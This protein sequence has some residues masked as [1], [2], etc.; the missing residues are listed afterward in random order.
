MKQ[1]EEDVGHRVVLLVV[2]AAG[3]LVAV[4]VEEVELAPRRLRDSGDGL[5]ARDVLASLP[6]HHV[7]RAGVDLARERLLRLTGVASSFDEAGRIELHDADDDR[8][9]MSC[10]VRP[11]EGVVVRTNETC[12][13]ALMRRAPTPREI[14]ERLKAVYGTEGD[15]ALAQRIGYPVRSVARWKAGHGMDFETTVDLLGRLGVLAW[16]TEAPTQPAEDGD[17]EASALAAVLGELQQLLEREVDLERREL[18]LLERSESAL[19]DLAPL[20]VRQEQLVAEM[21]GLVAELSRQAAR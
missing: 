12:Q 8:T 3:G 10:Q 2:V 20:L 6:A 16:N 17:E 9:L 18:H 14:V 21:R 7:P 11:D 19:S 15:E 1:L 13:S 4:A 5:R